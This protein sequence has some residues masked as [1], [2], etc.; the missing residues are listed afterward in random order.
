MKIQA[1]ATKNITEAI[2]GF[3]RFVRSH[4]L[5]VGM[6]ETQRALQAAEMGLLVRGRHPFKIALKI[7][8]C[9]SPE[10]RVLYD[11][12]FDLYWDTNP[13]DLQEERSRTRI[14]G[15][16]QLKEKTSLVMM[17]QGRSDDPSQE[18]KNISGASET[19]RLRTTDFAH[20]SEMDAGR[21]E[22]LADRLFKEMA[23]RWRRRMKDAKKQGPIHLR[24]TIRRSIPFGGEPMELYRRAR[25]PRKQRLIILLDVSGSMDKYSFYLLRFIYAL[26][27]RFRTPE[28]Y[29]FSTSLI[30]ISKVLQAG[31]LQAVLDIL[32]AQADNWSGGTRIGECFREFVEKHGKRVL[33]GAPVILILSD[34]LDTGDPAVLGREM[35][36][37]RRRARRIIWLNPLKGMKGYAPLAGGMR[38]ALPS[39]D[40]FYAAH[41]L[42]SLLQLEKI[43][44]YV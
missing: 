23:L 43:W 16:Q 9:T 40:E 17:G 11:R 5:N 10:E 41:N 3:A 4:G 38:A 2:V 42:N 31:R 26:R 14:S 36:R 22:E 28:V 13:M 44:N 1:F 12:L 18:G 19:E 37:L 30:R 39:V 29:I 34:G 20:V 21:L 7:L 6:E 25:R 15:A 35:I 32:S 24:K 27:Q 33:N 8:F